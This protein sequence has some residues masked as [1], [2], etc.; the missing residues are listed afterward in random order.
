[1]VSFFA[2]GSFSS[3]PFYLRLAA[4]IFFS[5][6]D[7]TSLQM[8]CG[9]FH[10][11]LLVFPYVYPISTRD[12]AHSLLLAHHF[13]FLT[14]I[15]EEDRF[16]LQGKEEWILSSPAIILPIQADW[17]LFHFLLSKRLLSCNSRKCLH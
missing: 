4:I 3:F 15:T 8:D 14:G 13:F 11:H 2:A 6:N 9:G 16:F 5:I 10:L 7:S 1:M 17:L 12:S